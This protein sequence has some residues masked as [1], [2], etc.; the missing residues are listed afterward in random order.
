MELLQDK[1]KE[2]GENL[3]QDI[4]ES[5][6]KNFMQSESILETMLLEKKADEFE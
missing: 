2:L 4:Y 6:G 1:Y 5:L 3:V